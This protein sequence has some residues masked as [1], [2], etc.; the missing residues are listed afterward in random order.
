MD[1]PVSDPPGLPGHRER[2]QEGGSGAAVVCRG[3]QNRAQGVGG[4]H[5]EQRG[6]APAET[7]EGET[8]G[9]LRRERMVSPVWL[10][11]CG[12]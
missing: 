2:K 5:S 1:G 11:R 10:V 3:A 9:G 6:P 7:W 4:G 8:A 12:T